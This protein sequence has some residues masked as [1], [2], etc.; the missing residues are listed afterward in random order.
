MPPGTLLH[1]RLRWAVPAVLAGIL[2]VVLLTWPA[3]ALAEPVGQAGEGAWYVVQRGDTLGRIAVDHGTTVAA[4]LA[5]NRIA[6]PNRIRVGQRIWIPAASG[7]TP[8][9]TATPVPGTGGEVWYT[10]VPGD[11]LG[12]IA[13][14]YGT[15]SAVIMRANGL[16]NPNLIRVGQRLRIPASAGP[17]PAPT[18]P[19]DPGD[20]TPTV[21]PTAPSADGTWY[22]VRS[23]DTLGAI[24][25]RHG[26]SVTAI[27]SANRLTN[28]NLIRVGQRLWI[29]GASGGD[30]PATPTPGS[31][32]PLPPSSAAGF[33]Y[34]FQIQPWFGADVAQALDATSGAGFGWVKVQ[35]PW[36]QFEGTGKGQYVWDDLDRLVDAVQARG[37]RLLVSIC[38]APDWARPGDTDRSLQ[39]PPANPQDLA[40]FAAAVAARYR[41]RIAAIEVW[42]EQNLVHEWG[43]EPL[44]AARYVRM[45]CA[46]YRSIK[47]QDSSMIVVA[48]GLTPTG[49]ND[50]V[51]AIDDVTYLRSMYQAG[52]R[53]CMDALGVHPSGYNN[54]PSARLGHQDPAEPAFKAHPSFFFFETMTR[55]RQVMVAYGDSG[56]ALWPTEFGWASAANPATGYEYARDVTEEEQARYLVDALTMMRNWGYVGPAFVWNLNFNVSNPG[57]E[58]AQF[59]VLG[60]PAWAALRDMPK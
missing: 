47:A 38:K 43:G 24:A 9:P 54:P 58:M 12:R 8:V 6:D 30:P 40:D 27:M 52:C 35:V 20:G 34:G 15:T 4:L 28:A 46:A 21:T 39:G 1:H 56:R 37:L 60:R 31:P 44:D 10:V 48:G 22:T 18:T 32:A 2:V 19:T 23:G 45:L 17:T 53:D 14:R 36:K 51:T 49:V 25:R 7:G 57:T 33:G 13:V 29:P 55:Y 50:G 42:N 16:T 26:V 59:G 11:T 41:G 3:A 5:A